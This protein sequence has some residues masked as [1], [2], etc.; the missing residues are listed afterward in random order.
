MSLAN[1]E[2]VQIGYESPS[3]T[4][5]KSIKK[6]NTFAS[7]LFFI[8][9]ALQFGINLSGINILRNLLE[10][11]DD[12]IKEGINNL[13]YMR[14]ILS[15]KKF[16]HNISFLSVSTSSRYF[17]FLESNKLLDNWSSNTSSLLSEKII[18]KKDK[19][20]L[21]EDYTKKTYNKLWDIFK[22][23]ETYYIENEYKYKFIKN[24]NIITYREFL[25]N[26]C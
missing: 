9:W 25:N 12:G 10:E 22:N 17:K 23:V 19:Y 6:N 4:I 26:E 11:D 14:F 20:I 16:H 18:N 5:L 3:N 24:H 8:K 7:N 1:F 13:F 15:S 2:S 21:F